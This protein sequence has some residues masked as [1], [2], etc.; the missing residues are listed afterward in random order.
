[1]GFWHRLEEVRDHGDVLRH[2]FYTRWSAGELSADELSVYSGQYRHAVVALAAAS[3]GAARAAEPEVAAELWEHASEEAD[4][5]ALWD[6]FVHAVGG[7]TSA[8]ALPE[9]AACA[10]TWGRTE[11]P[12]L[13]SLVALYVI[14]AAQPAIA[15][16]KRVGLRDHYGIA[17]PS[18]TAYFDVHV[19]RDVEHAAAGRELIEARLGAADEDALLGAAESVLVA[20]WRLLDGVQSA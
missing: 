8:R 1:M 6:G 11:R 7:S 19:E 4:H 12:L 10:E 3:A 18:A 20:N 2:P 13:E 17:E 14:E 5:V 9:T 16:A 15:E